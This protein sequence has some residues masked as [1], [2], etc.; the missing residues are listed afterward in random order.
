[1]RAR[2]AVGSVTSSGGGEGVIGG[3]PS[4]ALGEEEP[5]T[6][7]DGVRSWREVEGCCLVSDLGS[8]FLAKRPKTMVQNDIGQWKG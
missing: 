3:N 7:G 8:D 2:R 1:M 6:D 5:T 4:S